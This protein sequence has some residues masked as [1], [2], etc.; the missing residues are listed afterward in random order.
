MAVTNPDL[1]GS[2]AAMFAVLGYAHRAVGID[3]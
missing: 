2:G 3:D 1:S